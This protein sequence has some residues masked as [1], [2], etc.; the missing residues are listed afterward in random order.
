MEDPYLVS[1]FI[2]LF[3]GAGALWPY[4]TLVSVPDYFDLLFP[5]TNFEFYVPLV[6]N[7]PSLVV[8]TAMVKYGDRISLK[9]R[10]AVPLVLFF[11]L[12]SSLTLWGTFLRD[13]GGLIWIYILTMLLVGIAYA[14]YMSSLFGLTSTFPALYTQALM[15]G[16]GISVG[17]RRYSHLTNRDSSS[18]CC[19]C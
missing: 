10:I 12:V 11:V 2:L 15:G 18:L 9:V 17:S 16:N 19:V 8:L 1:Y 13:F 7:V 4:N 14:V 3:L 5:G 6:I